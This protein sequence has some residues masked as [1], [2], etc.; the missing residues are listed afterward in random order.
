MTWTCVFLI[1]F[2]HSWNRCIVCLTTFY[3]F[4]LW[5][6]V[7][8][9]FVRTRFCVLVLVVFVN[10]MNLTLTHIIFNFEWDRT[11]DALSRRNSHFRIS[12]IFSLF[13]KSSVSRIIMHTHIF[14]ILNL[15]WQSV[16]TNWI[17]RDEMRRVKRNAFWSCQF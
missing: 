10:I 1:R 15:A 14:V 16:L 5:R 17:P 3:G 13:S 11:G 2:N 4:D 12:V 7:C 8:I 6:C 9:L